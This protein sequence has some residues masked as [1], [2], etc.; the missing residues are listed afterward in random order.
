M[1]DR[2]R[3]PLA[4]GPF[5]V[6]LARTDDPDMHVTLRRGTPADARVVADLWVRARRA[7]TDIPATIH[8]ADDIRDW[9][10]GRVIPH[11]DLWLA[12]NQ[13]GAL[14]GLL[15]LDDDCV[16]QLYV[17]PTLTGR[18]V[19]SELLMLAMRQRPEGLRL[20]T[21]AANVAAQ[22]FYERHGFVESVRT[23]GDN[24]EQAADILYIWPGPRQ[25]N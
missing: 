5:A 12:E 17:E 20:W 15:V 10:A 18:G 4:Q 13:A 19:G 7:A 6:A 2:L 23:D 24:E 25:R 21:F 1:A 14:V 11:T 9:I 3:D 8:T 16:D 22:R